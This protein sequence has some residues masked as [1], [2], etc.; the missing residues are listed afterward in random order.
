MEN[1]IL[2]SVIMSE[3]N[4][5]EELL[6]DSIKSILEQTYKNFE[7]IIIDDKGKI[8]LKEII[9]SFNDERIKIVENEKNKGL[10]YSLNKAIS[11]AN[12]K[13]LVRMDTDDFSYK[14]RIKK[15]VEFMEQHT[16]YAVAGTRVDYYDGEKVFAE[17]NFSGEVT[18]EILMQGSSVITHPSVIMRKEAVESVGLYQNYKRCEDYALWIELALN[19]YR[20]YV[21][22][23]KLLRY[24]LALNDYS[25]R[26]LKTRKDFFRLLNEKYK[27]LNPSPIKYY[28]LY[29][30][31]FLAGIMPYKL[32]AMYHKHKYKK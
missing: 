14:D 6:R 30:K 3:Y 21:M 32:M 19:G 8:N 29:I 16:E 27:K 20:L 12:G 25:K 28:A 1:D 26:S 15:Q 11:E 24:H 23:E 4:T 17:T 10:V 18:K 22:E 13:Y 9:K 2:V 7:F 5:D 31:T